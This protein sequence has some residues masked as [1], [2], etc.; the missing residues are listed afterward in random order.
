MK[1]QDYLIANPSE[2]YPVMSYKNN[3]NY[4]YPFMKVMDNQT[5]L[6]EEDVR[7]RFKYGDFTLISSQW[8]DMKMIKRLKI[9]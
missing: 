7:Y 8:M 2:R 3:R 4:V 1:T 9:K 6:I 5:Y